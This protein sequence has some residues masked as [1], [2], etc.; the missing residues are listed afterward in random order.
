MAC[1]YQTAVCVEES[2]QDPRFRDLC[3]AHAAILSEL[4]EGDQDS[5]SASHGQ[6]REDADVGH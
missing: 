6:E 5:S 4:L 2:S 1:R 3:E